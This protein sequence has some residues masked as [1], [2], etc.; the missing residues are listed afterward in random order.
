MTARLPAPGTTVMSPLPTPTETLLA[1]GAV[2]GRDPVAVL[3][4]QG[5]ALE[6]AIND[7]GQ[8][9]WQADDQRP[10]PAGG[11]TRGWVNGP[12]SEP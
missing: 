2:I 6:A 11:E 4:D 10:A 3:A 9:K 5:D 7:G 1:I 12:S 8:H